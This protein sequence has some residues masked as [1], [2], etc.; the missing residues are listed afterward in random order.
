MLTK[1]A[2]IFITMTTSAA[3][4]C[5]CTKLKGK[6]TGTAVLV[7]EK[8]I[9]V[10]APIKQCAL[11]SYTTDGQP[12]TTTITDK[13]NGTTDVDWDGSKNVKVKYVDCN[14]CEN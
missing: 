5:D 3:Y 8:I 13:D 2:L 11:V 14:L 10:T 4:A 7:G 12:S 6:C 1:L 9:R